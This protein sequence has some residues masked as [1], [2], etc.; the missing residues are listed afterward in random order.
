[1]SPS[2]K[3]TNS[4]ERRNQHSSTTHTAPSTHHGYPSPARALHIGESLFSLDT[5]ED[6]VLREDIG[7]RT[8]GRREKTKHSRDARSSGRSPGDVDDDNEQ[9]SSSD[10]GSPYSAIVM[11]PTEVLARILAHLDPL[12]LGQCGAVCKAF[13]GVARDDATWRLAF[14]LAF[15]V[16]ESRSTPIF[17]RAESSGWKAEYTR[18]TDLLR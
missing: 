2:H 18:R 17:R 10:D 3:D 7:P 4:K 14:A 11:L 16:A 12:S 9:G 5:G 13:A 6:D 15:Q 1:M 8:V